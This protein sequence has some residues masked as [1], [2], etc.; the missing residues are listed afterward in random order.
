MKLH[1]HF[2]I[3]IYFRQYSSEHEDDIVKFVVRHGVYDMVKGNCLW[4]M[5]EERKVRQSKGFTFWPPYH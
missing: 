3:D 2:G 1:Y 5:M 4:K